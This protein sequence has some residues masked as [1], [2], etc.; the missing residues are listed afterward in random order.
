MGEKRI[1]FGDTKMSGKLFIYRITIGGR[2]E[3]L[4]DALR[5]ASKIQIK[6]FYP[7]DPDHY[8][9]FA[10]T[11]LSEILNAHHFIFSVVPHDVEVAGTL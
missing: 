4:H 7:M 5:D 11:D 2:L 9:V 8:A 6:R 10:E 3:E 1:G